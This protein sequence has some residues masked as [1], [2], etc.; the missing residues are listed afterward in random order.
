M[1]CHHAFSIGGCTTP[2]PVIEAASCTAEEEFFVYFHKLFSPELIFV[3]YIACEQ[4]SRYA[5]RK[6]L[7][8]LPNNISEKLFE[9]LLQ[10]PTP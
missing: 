6:I 5:T 2:L 7:D 8:S 4:L 10:K 3:Q 1:H 9:Y